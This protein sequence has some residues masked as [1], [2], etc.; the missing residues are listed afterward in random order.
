MTWSKDNLLAIGAADNRI[1]VISSSGNVLQRCDT[2]DAPRCLKFSEMKREK[3]GAYEESTVSFRL[4]V[5]RKIKS[6]KLKFLR[7]VQLL[8]K[9]I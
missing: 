8:G 9:N 7:L 6:L 2:N 5:F 3:R 4:V 1:S